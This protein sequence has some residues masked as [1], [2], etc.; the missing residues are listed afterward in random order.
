MSTI[1]IG[2]GLPVK[3]TPPPGDS[4]QAS[5]ASTGTDTRHG[6]GLGRLLRRLYQIRRS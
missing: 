2:I 6:T 5:V 3:Q 1:D 4:A